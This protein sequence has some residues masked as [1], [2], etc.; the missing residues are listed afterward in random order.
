MVLYL[1]VRVCVC[2]CTRL[3]VVLCPVAAEGVV[4]GCSY[5]C[6]ISSGGTGERCLPDFAY[7]LHTVGWLCAAAT[8]SKAKQSKKH[9]TTN[10]VNSQLSACRALASASAR[11]TTANSS[12][13]TLLL[14]PS[15]CC[16]AS[17]SAHAAM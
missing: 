16:S 11:C 7:D 2:V 17:S 15:R 10:Q 3:R 5:S 1:Q 4:R 8:Q 6:L 12:S 13:R 14:V 9:P